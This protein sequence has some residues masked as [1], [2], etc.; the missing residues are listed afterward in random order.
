ME[1][2]R[3]RIAG[4]GTKPDIRGS[5]DLSGGVIEFANRASTP[6][7]IR[8]QT[9]AGIA[10]PY[11][12]IEISGNNVQNSNTNITLA[13][14]GKFSILDQGVYRSTNNSIVGPQG[15][16][17]FVMMGGSTFICQTTDGFYG[18]ASFPSPPSLR[19]DVERVVL[20][21]GSTIVFGRQGNQNI[22]TITTYPITDF[23][24]VEIN[25]GGFKTLQSAIT[26]KGE[27]SLR[28]GFLQS[29]VSNLL[30]LDVSA[31]CGS[32]G[33]FQSFVNGPLCKKGDT[34]FLFPV[35]S[36]LGST[37]HYRPIRISNITES[38]SFTASFF[39]ASAAN[40]P[41]TA[42]GLQ[43]V[44]NCEYWELQQS[45]NAKASITLI[46]NEQSPCNV[47]E[48]YVT[49]PAST[50]VAQFEQDSW[51]SFGGTG[52]GH[53]SPGEGSVTCDHVQ[54]FQRFALGST[55]VGQL[56]LPVG[57]YQLATEVTEQGI[58]LQWDAGETDA[59]TAFYI[60]HS[61]D[62]VNFAVI[63]FLPW[64]NGSVSR[65][66]HF[67]HAQPILGWNYYRLKA[68]LKSGEAQFSQISRILFQNDEEAVRVYPNPAFEKIFVHLKDPRS[69]REIQV[70][71]IS[72]LVLRRVAPTDFTTAIIISALGKGI[73][74]LRFIRE[75]RTS[76]VP[77]LKW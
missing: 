21:P 58:F 34:P 43:S 49:Q 53:A 54:N 40:W 68:T 18:A 7:T 77:F 10:I 29:T 26:V 16:Q 30:T 73:Y 28:N 44:S 71:N 1:G 59:V 23:Q 8:G 55:S 35:G 36:V 42:V 24:N 14:G 46:W 72:G 60:E 31:S 6:Q 13:P 66:N 61:I 3:W 67:L 20:H 45:G 62:G 56:L 70:V 52:I 38:S 69:I 39:R 2:G 32:G 41:I 37:C 51:R 57:S 33:S 15:V 48:A 47:P 11:S 17:Q 63:A 74:Y 4:T 9:A 5:F 19:N 75:D 22:R 64:L 27:L 65:L 76:F 12:A 25:G 50:V